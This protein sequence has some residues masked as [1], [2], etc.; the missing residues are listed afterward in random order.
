MRAAHVDD[1]ADA[2]ASRRP[3]VAKYVAV[4]AAVLVVVGLG[5]GVANRS[6]NGGGGDSS[7][8][9]G[10][11]SVTTKGSKGAESNNATRDASGSD[12][13]SITPLAAARSFGTVD[14]ADTLR[15]RVEAALGSAG[16][17]TAPLEQNGATA[18]AA[19]PAACVTKQARALG[20]DP[21]LVLDGSI[22]YAGTPGHVFV[23]RRGNDALIVVVADAGDTCRLLVS[24]LLHQGT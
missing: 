2:R 7:S 16:A 8:A 20:V 1:L 13:T 19:A 18:D 15:Q 6:G 12:A 14:D 3:R 11:A 24:Q 10:R 22:V 9:A 4:A 23:F 17:P 5:V 21:A